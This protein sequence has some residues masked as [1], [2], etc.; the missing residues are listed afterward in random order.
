MLVATGLLQAKVSKAQKATIKFEQ[1]YTQAIADY[2]ALEVKNQATSFMQQFFIKHEFYKVKTYKR[3]LA[4]YKQYKVAQNNQEKTELDEFFETI[5]M[6]RPEI[7]GIILY[8]DFHKEYVMDFTKTGFLDS[9]RYRNEKQ[10]VFIFSQKIKILADFIE[11]YKPYLSASLMVQ[12]LELQKQFGLIKESLEK[13]YG[14]KFVQKYSK[15]P[16]VFTYF[17]IALCYFSGAFVFG[18]E[19]GMLIGLAISPIHCLCCLM[20]TVGFALILIPL[21][22]VTMVYS[23]RYLKTY[24]DIRPAYKDWLEFVV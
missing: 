14:S 4:R 20:P 1:K 15:A 7:L 17:L 9:S 10:F 19:I 13:T 18:Y 3:L 2:K 5:K 22:V 6:M 23:L 21:S 8:Q 24:I 11:Q 12:M 16:N